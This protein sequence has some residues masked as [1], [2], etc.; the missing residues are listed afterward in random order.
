MQ[1]AEHTG[2]ALGH[3]PALLRRAE[4]VAAVVELVEPSVSDR[5][6]GHLAVGDLLEER[7]VGAV[8]HGL[9]GGVGGVDVRGQHLEAGTVPAR[10]DAAS[11]LL[12][13]PGVDQTSRAELEQPRRL[14]LQGPPRHP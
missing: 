8:D 2:R 1:P 3:R 7:A 9:A 5:G 12:Q 4:G 14:A 11:R 13:Q 10:V 6:R